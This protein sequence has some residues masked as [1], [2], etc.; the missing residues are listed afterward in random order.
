MA[1]FETLLYYQQPLGDYRV[2]LVFL[3]LCVTFA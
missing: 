3:G 2:A 1:E